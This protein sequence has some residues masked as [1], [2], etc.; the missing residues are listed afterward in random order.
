M[1]AAVSA[2]AASAAAIGK[3]AIAGAPNCGE[4]IQSTARRLANN[5]SLDGNEPAAASPTEQAPLIGTSAGADEG[6]D[7][8]EALQL[9]CEN[10]T[11]RAVRES[12]LTDFLNTHPG[13]FVGQCP[14]TP[15]PSP[16][17]TATPSPTAK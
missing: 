6:F 7:P 10:G 1:A 12:Q 8:L 4:T 14:P 17:L 16:T 9:V 3:A 5:I 11:Q 15:S 2:D 13:S